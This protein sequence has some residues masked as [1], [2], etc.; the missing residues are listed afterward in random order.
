MTSDSRANPPQLATWFVECVTSREES[1]GVLGDLAE[2][3]AEV[4]RRSGRDPARRWYW[5][6]CRRT[7]WHL[8]ASP[9]WLRPAATAMIA[10]I[11]ISLTRAFGPLTSAT[12][13]AIVTRYPVYWYV[14]APLF[15]GFASVSASFLTG[16]VL[17]FVAPEVRFR[18]VSAAVAVI[19]VLGL[20]LAV[21]R[22]IAMLLFGPPLAIRVTVASSAT[23]WAYGML[24]FGGATLAGAVL[25]RTIPLRGHSSPLDGDIDRATPLLWMTAL[26]GGLIGATMFGRYAADVIAPVQHATG[27][28]TLRSQITTWAVI[29]AVAMPAAYAAWRYDRALTG[30]VVGLSGGCLGGILSSVGVTALLVLSRNPNH[31]RWADGRALG[32]FGDALLVVWALTAMS[33]AVAGLCGFV[34]RPFGRRN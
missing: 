6:Q 8:A 15:W 20:W 18:P 22:P 16:F 1:D 21:D 12:A 25:A 33:G 3:F 19:A 31:I 14:P 26:S 4:A 28:M 10:L 27:V 23:R 9:L 34:L 17:A 30:F 13:S 5:R 11:G 32:P 7:V 24:T 2:E 29:A